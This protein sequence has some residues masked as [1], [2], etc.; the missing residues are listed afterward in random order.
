[1]FRRRKAEP[2]PPGFR[3]LWAAAVTPHRRE[4]HEADHAAMLELVDRLAKSGVDG[5]VLLGATGEFI[6]IKLEDRQRLLHLAIKRSR[7]P[8]IAGVSHSTL[9]GAITLAEAAIDSGAVGLLLMPP[10]FYRYTPD[11]IGEFYRLF[12]IAIGGALPTLLYNIPAFT[13]AIPIE[14]ARELLTSGDFAG[15]KDSSGDP[16]YLNA[17]LAI[18]APHPLSILCGHDRLLPHALRAG[19]SGAVS[20]VACAVPELM[21]ALFHA[22]RSND[23]TTAGQLESEV[24]SFIDWIDR[25][26][27]P[28]GISAA[29]EARGDTVGPPAIPLNAE[30]FDS[31]EEFKAWF[32]SWLPFVLNLH[33]RSLT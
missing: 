32:T 25:F 12:A 1:M 27:V 9:D 2:E 21:L 31:L 15:I 10:Y 33:A 5:I 19:V 11:D 8:I 29:C 18:E 17:L 23:A 16:A 22:T 30:Q 14:L 26:P 7:V 6:N 13:N 4:R 3:G 24:N 20:G 28:V